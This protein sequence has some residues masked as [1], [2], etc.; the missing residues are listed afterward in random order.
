MGIMRKFRRRIK[1]FFFAHK[2]N[3]FKPGVFAKEAA[4]AIVLVLLAVEGLY[5][6]Q[7]HIVL[8]NNGFIATVLPAALA[9]L[10]NADRATQGLVALTRDP[11]L[12]AVAQAKADDMA[13]KGYFA[14]VS[15]DGKTPW[16]WLQQAGYSYT[17]AGENL[18]V[19]FTDSTDVETAWMQSPAHRANILKQEYTHVGIAVAEGMYEGK[20]VTFVAQFF[21]ASKE[22]VAKAAAA[23]ASAAPKPAEQVPA[24]QV[25]EAVAPAPAVLG[26]AAVPAQPPA[27]PVAVAMTSPTK[28]LWYVFAGAAALLALLF[29]LMLIVHARKRLLYV[30]F[31]GCGFLLLGVTVALMLYGGE[32]AHVT[33]PSDSQSASVARAL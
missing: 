24:T 32:S 29:A 1:H 4:L 21:A 27:A 11:A 5:L 9:D 15:P 20:E 6:V 19:D 7:V 2:G 30:E 17:Y 23:V 28:I 13:A 22:D 16:Y 33:L 8:K 14:H 18:A 12:D 10:A 3:K 25:A 31:L 26:E